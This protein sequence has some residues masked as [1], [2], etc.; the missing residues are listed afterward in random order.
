MHKWFPRANYAAQDDAIYIF[1]HN[2]YR[3]D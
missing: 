2:Y 3:R 1:L